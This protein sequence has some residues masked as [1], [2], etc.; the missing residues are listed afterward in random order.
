M[1]WPTHN[2]LE[3]REAGLRLCSIEKGS[4]WRTG[5]DGRVMGLRRAS[6]A[7]PE[8]PLHMTRDDTMCSTLV[9]RRGI[10]P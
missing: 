8:H 2:A 10:K 9:V 7:A 5:K 1:P 3:W 4:G 6:T